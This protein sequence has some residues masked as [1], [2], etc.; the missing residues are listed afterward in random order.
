MNLKGMLQRILFGLNILALIGLLF[1]YVALFV[2]PEKFW[3][4]SF[5]GLGYPI[6]LIINLIFFV[7]WLIVRWKLALFSG[8]LIAA[9]AAKITDLYQW[10]TAPSFGKIEQFKDADSTLHITSYNVRLFDLYNWTRNKFSRNS[11]LELLQRE[12]SDIICF[13]EFF[14]EDTGKF[15]TLDTLLQ[16]QPARYYHVEHTAHV[17]KVNHWGIA[18]FSRFPIVGKGKISFRDSTDNISIYTDVKAYGD[19]VRIYNLHLESIRFKREDYKAL[20]EI[21]GEDT[22]ADVN[23]PQRIIGKMRRAFIRRARQTDIISRH[24]ALCRY[25][26]IV[27]GDFNDTPHSYAYHQISKNLRDGFKEAGSGIGSSYA[28]LIPMLRI[29]FVLFSPEKFNALYFH[30]TRKKLSDHYPVSCILKINQNT[31]Q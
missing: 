4:A 14:Y 24:I 9:G 22:L 23:S 11:I 28:G 2:S 15:N 25:P 8:L 13:Q 16:I 27:C 6:L 30:T 29:D 7:F 31:K 10:R 17:K 19:T 20:K 1:S 12:G 18:T 21:T 5:F 26:V 3:M